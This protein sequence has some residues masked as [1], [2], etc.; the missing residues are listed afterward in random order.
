MPT[1]A[2]LLCRLWLATYVGAWRMAGLN[3][4]FVA[5][6]AALHSARGLF[7]WDA[8]RRVTGPGFSVFFVALG[9]RRCLLF[10]PFRVYSAA[11]F[12]RTLELWTAGSRAVCCLRSSLLFRWF[13]Q[14]VRCGSGA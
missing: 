8:R 4:I 7:A 9:R 1:I 14:A 2:D 3:G 13:V 11:C 10:A 12:W 5:M 6:A